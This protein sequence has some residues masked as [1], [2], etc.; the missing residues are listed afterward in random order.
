MSNK[1]NSDLLIKRGIITQDQVNKAKEEAAKTGM[2]TEKA[3][4][5]LGFIS[6]VDIANVYADS[7]GIPFI[8][9]SDYLIDPEVVKLVP[10]AVAS[11]YKAVPLF[12]IGNSLTV[13]MADPEDVAAL[14]EIRIKSKFDTVEPVLATRDMIQNVIDQYYGA[15]GSAEELVKGMTKEKMETSA[16]STKGLAAAAEEA[17]VIKLVNLIIMQAVKD[18]ASDIHI[19][20]SEE[21]VLIRFRIDGILH[22][23]QQIP[24]H[25][26]SALASRVKVMARMDISEIRNPQDGRIQLKMES[27][28]LDLRV[29]T[30]PT[31]HGEN[32]VMRILDKSSVI[33]GLK[34]LGFS[35]NELSEFDKIIRRP[36]GIM[37]VTGPTGSGKTTTL[38]AALSAINSIEKNIITIE[39]PVE[40]EIPLIRQTQVNP[41]AGLTFA[42]G[43]RSILRQDPDIIMVGEIRD[44][45]TADISI[46]ASLTG[47]L[48]LSTLHT[49][50]AASSL[51]RLID[52][53]IEPFLIASSVIGI[54]A[55]R[56]V[57][58]I[59]PKCKE[60]YEPSDEVV[61]DLGLPQKM[62]LSRGKGCM[63]CRNTGFTG[64]IGIFELLT[65]NEEI[66]NM[67][68]AK[69]SASDIKKKAIEQCMRVLRDDGM[70]KVKS[71]ITTAEEVLR[72]TEEI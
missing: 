21:K 68:T 9:L 28:S 72:V 66:K 12:K 15:I 61:R 24:K 30:F 53:G 29:S 11:K 46:Q 4:E 31:M 64:R 26:Q 44:K 14:D 41:R 10:E 43:L 20:P 37:L 33:L 13:A 6:E 32:I 19:E 65:V 23:V 69:R 49:N 71:G 45:E 8:D 54:L 67:V 39:D 5:K 7:L 34:E 2:T 70:E 59:C 36:N 57:R 18:K 62:D 52:M 56:L 42:N 1:I 47:H 38:Y 16:K 22:E 27:K 63:H 55:Q 40:Y 50:D 60:K 25:L 17:P 58:V 48:V 35:K 51:T 3:L